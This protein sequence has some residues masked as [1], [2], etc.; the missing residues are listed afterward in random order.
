MSLPFKRVKTGGKQCSVWLP[1]IGVLTSFIRGCLDV[2]TDE[3]RFLDA[4]GRASRPGVL[5]LEEATALSRGPYATDRALRPAATVIERLGLG[6]AGLI[7]VLNPDWVLLGSLHKD[8]LGADPRAAAGR[9]CL[10]PPLEPRQP[11][12]LCSAVPWRAAA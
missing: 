12:C 10:A 1:A 7:N 11:A 4:A 9:H 5:V 3:L 2:Q 8:L 6:S